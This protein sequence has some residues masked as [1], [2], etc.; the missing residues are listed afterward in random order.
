MVGWYVVIE[1]GTADGAIVG[2]AVGFGVGADDGAGVGAVVLPTVGIAVWAFVGAVVDS[3]VGKMKGND[4]ARPGGWFGDR[5]PG[6][7][8]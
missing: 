2:P 1:E 5:L 7:G 6:V 3:S 8:T 4:V